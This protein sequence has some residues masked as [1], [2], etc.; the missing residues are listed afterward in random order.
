MPR[1]NKAR[2]LPGICLG[3]DSIKEMFWLVLSVIIPRLRDTPEEA[4]ERANNIPY[5]LSA[6]GRA[7]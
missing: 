4:F 5:G 1:W 2:R 6:D 3:G 7:K